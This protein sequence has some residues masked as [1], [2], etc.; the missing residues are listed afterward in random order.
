M[1]RKVVLILTLLL[2][3]FMGSAC[4]WNPFTISGVL[5]CEEP[6]MRIYIENDNSS[7]DEAEWFKEDGT[8]E[9]LVFSAMHGDFFIF[10]FREDGMYGIDDEDILFRGDY[11]CSEDMLILIMDDGNRFVFK[12]IADAK[13]DLYTNTPDTNGNETATPSYTVYDFDLSTCEWGLEN[14]PIDDR[15]EE[16]KDAETAVEQAKKLWE[17]YLS[18]AGNHPY[19][20]ING[21]PVT[22][23]FDEERECWCVSGT[24]QDGVDGAVPRAVIQQDGEVLAVWMD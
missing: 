13:S 16:I 3:V 20:P 12:K 2:L 23:G 9:K 10:R 4:T 6:H 17:K 18:K 11:R 24:L 8:V 21:L 14:F 7:N 15:V 5:E 1:R 19:N 22:V